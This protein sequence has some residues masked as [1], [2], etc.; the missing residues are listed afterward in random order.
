MS[1]LKEN[2]KSA[3]IQELL[4]F[5]FLQVNTVINF[6]Y[7]QT[8]LYC[9]Y[10]IYIIYA[11]R[12]KNCPARIRGSTSVFFNIEL[13]RDNFYFTKFFFKD[14]ILKQFEF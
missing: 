11:R 4:I 3:G 10:F 13:L 8:Y 12:L 5:P 2:L 9:R 7:F 1:E 14:L 6:S